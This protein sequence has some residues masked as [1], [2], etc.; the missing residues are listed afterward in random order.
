MIR[1]D[2][3][4][5]GVLDQQAATDAFQLQLRGPGCL[6]TS[7]QDPHPRLCFRDGKDAFL[8]VR[9]QDDLHELLFDDLL[10]GLPVQAA[11][12][13]DDA[14]ERGDRIGFI[15]RR[16]CILERPCR[17]HA[18]GIGMLDYDAGRTVKPRHAFQRRVG[19]GKIIVG[20]RLPL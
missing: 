19:V 14:A 11:V 10:R 2:R 7:H 18:A 4:G 9:R 5:I 12:E 8:Q 1:L 17:R 16:V 13:S 15:S 3:S 6:F 20:K